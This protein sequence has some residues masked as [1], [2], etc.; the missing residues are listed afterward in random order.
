MDVVAILVI[1]QVYSESKNVVVCSAHLPYHSADPLLSKEMV[2]VINYCK[3]KQLGLVLRCDANSHHDERESSDIN[4]RGRVML[5]YMGTMDLVL[6][7][8]GDNPTF[9]TKRKQMGIDSTLCSRELMR[10][11][12]GWRVSLEPLLSDY[13]HILLSLAREEE[14]RANYRNPQTACWASYGGRGIE[15]RG[16]LECFVVHFGTMEDTEI[17]VEFLQQAYCLFL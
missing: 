6:L 2:E 11:V 13:R 14:E 5:V 12:C 10:E 8:Q 4:P 17:A 7:N 16:K 1:Y 3:E 9:L 15:I